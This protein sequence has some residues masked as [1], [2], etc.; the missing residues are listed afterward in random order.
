[1]SWDVHT[2]TWAVLRRWTM[3][4]NVTFQ[5]WPLFLVLFLQDALISLALFALST[6]RLWI[7]L[8]S[9]FFRGAVWDSTLYRSERLSFDEHFFQQ[10]CQHK[11]PLISPSPLPPLTHPS[12]VP[13]SMLCGKQIAEH[14]QVK[15]SWE[16]EREMNSRTWTDVLHVRPKPIQQNLFSLDSICLSSS[17]NNFYPISHRT[18]RYKFQKLLIS[19][20]NFVQIDGWVRNRDLN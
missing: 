11:H 19:F 14:I 17:I 18:E 20:L 5:N 2:G 8:S 13:V 12:A 7:Y 6:S 10:Q 16:R 15:N 1:M 3:T 4:K 9:Q